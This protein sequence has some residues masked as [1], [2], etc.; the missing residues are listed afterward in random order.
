MSQAVN[1]HVYF[2]PCVEHSS[3]QWQLC[4]CCHW[5]VSLSLSILQLA[6]LPCALVWLLVLTDICSVLFYQLL[7][8]TFLSTLYT[9]IESEGGKETRIRD[10]TVAMATTN[11]GGEGYSPAMPPTTPPPD[12]LPCVKVEGI[13]ASWSY[14]RAKLVLSNISMEVKKVSWKCCV[15]VRASKCL[16]ST[17]YM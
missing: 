12:E 17:S 10:E 1:S 3:G 14:E 13:S 4:V 16:L 15:W 6:I 2:K 8:T 5:D 11:L 9:C 7:F